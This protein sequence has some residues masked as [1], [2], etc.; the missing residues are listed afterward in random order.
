MLHIVRVISM[1]DKVNM[2]VPRPKRLVHRAAG[3]GDDGQRVRL[4]CI[5]SFVNTGIL[6][7]LNLT[8]LEVESVN[9]DT[10]LLD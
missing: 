10:Q 3:A 2:D 4:I 1:G 6:L 5:P 8:T 9:F 7:L